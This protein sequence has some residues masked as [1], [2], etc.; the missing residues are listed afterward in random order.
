MVSVTF[1]PGS[2]AQPPNTRPSRPLTPWRRCAI[3]RTTRRAHRRRS[4]TS[5][6]N[7]RASFGAANVSAH[8]GPSEQVRRVSSPRP[9]RFGPHRR[10]LSDGDRRETDLVLASRPRRSRPARARVSIFPGVVPRSHPRR[11]RS[12]P[13][14]RRARDRGGSSGYD[15]PRGRRDDYDGY[16]RHQA[17]PP[18]QG[19]GGDRHHPYGG[20]GPRGGAGLGPLPLP[21]A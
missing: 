10:V 3:A 8:H 9:R 19:G 14:T 11:L 7:P 17:P 6:R 2:R 15:D 21:R 12:P 18:P 4:N 1:S 20:G 16:G 5:S 13:P